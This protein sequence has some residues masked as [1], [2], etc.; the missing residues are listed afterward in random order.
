MSDH[1]PDVLLVNDSKVVGE[2]WLHF[3]VFLP[4]KR[5]N[6]AVDHALE[7]LEVEVHF[8][9]CVRGEGEGQRLSWRGSGY[10]LGLNVLMVKFLSPPELESF[11]KSW[12]VF[13]TASLLSVV[14]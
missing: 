9:H 13:P 1:A 3:E 5:A 8:L 11:R 10:G 14:M 6:V 12:I 4:T 7:V 2:A